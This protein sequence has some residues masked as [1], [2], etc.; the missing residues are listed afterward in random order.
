MN[1]PIIELWFAFF[2]GMK[3]VHEWECLHG[4]TSSLK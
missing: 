2:V 4:F 3:G 1:N